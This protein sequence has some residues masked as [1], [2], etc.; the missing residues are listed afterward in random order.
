[1][2]NCLKLYEVHSFST[3]SAFNTVVHWRELG[4]CTSYNFRQFAIICQKLSDLVEVWRN[5]N[6]NNFACFLRH[7]VDGDSENK[8]CD[9]VMRIEV[10]QEESEQNEVDGW[11][12]EL[13]P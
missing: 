7:G 1:M 2:A 4:E 11:R 3:S 6:K 13:I 5:Y 12:R 9:V 10:N 8:D